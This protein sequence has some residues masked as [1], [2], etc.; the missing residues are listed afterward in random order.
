LISRREQRFVIHE[1]IRQYSQQ[2]LSP[3][4][5]QQALQ[6]LA[7]VT[8]ALSELWFLHARDEQQTEW[9]RRIEQEHDNI[10]TVLNW[11]L[12]ENIEVGT[13]LSGNLEHFW[14]SRGY[15]REGMEWAKQFAHLYQQPNTVR[16]RALWTQT[17]LAKELSEYDLARNSAKEY[18][19]LASQLNDPKALALVEKFYGL[20]EREQGNLELGKSHLEQA[21]TMFEALQDDNSIAVCLNDLGI[22]YALQQDLGTSKRYFEDSLRLKRQI[23]DKQGIAYAI[24][25]LGIIAGQQG[26]FN[27]ERVM[28][29]ESLRLKREL[30][31]QQGIANGLGELGRN[32]FDQN[33]IEAALEYYIEAL[34]I[35]CRLE[36]RFSIIHLIRNFSLLAYQLGQIKQ[37]LIF[38]TAS[39][40]LSY[41]YRITPSEVWLKRKAQWQENSA[42]TPAQLAQ[43]EFETER[44]DL[45]QVVSQIFA[46]T[47]QVQQQHLRQVSAEPLEFSPV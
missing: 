41:Q 15:H 46:W 3:D 25:N 47:H 30:G 16:L 9:S 6:G 32:A 7:K 36:R 29:E 31:D 11:A 12:Q 35:Y 4:N 27:L 33:N 42:L 18:K 38:E 21:K 28:Q 20:L 17:S 1:L 19:Q 22:I 5:Q 13:Q 2:Q 26:D 10:R 44:L 45:S 23:N 8:T 37:A 40:A 14:Y 24:S 39:I 43:L 34:E